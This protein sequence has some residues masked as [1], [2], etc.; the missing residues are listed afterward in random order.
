MP[1]HL[2]HE[3]GPVTRFVISDTRDVDAMNRLGLGGAA[4][5]GGRMFTGAMALDLAT[6]KRL[7]LVE[8][9]ADEAEFCLRSVESNLAMAGFTMDDIVKIT[10]YVS[11]SQYVDEVLDV[12]D[13]AFAHRTPPKRITL[14]CGIAGECRVEL[15]VM[16][17]RADGGTVEIS[18][19]QGGRS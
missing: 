13:A 4:V 12:L 3:G 2:Q 7:D 15:E 11:E 19:V 17:Y 8:T 5:A 6:I 10:N 18:T 14:V 16:A 9:A 1:R